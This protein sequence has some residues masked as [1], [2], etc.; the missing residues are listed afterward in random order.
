MIYVA[1]NRSN[2]ISVINGSDHSVVKVIH[3]IKGVD[4]LA[5]NAKTDKIYV[6]NS[7]IVSV[8]DGKTNSWMGP[9]KVGNAPI[10][11]RLLI[12]RQT[13]SMWLIKN[14]IRSR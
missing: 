2:T 3:R 11:R 4:A 14:L 10:G 13:W 1:Y 7:G 6:V 12:Q 9:V 8:I 5:V